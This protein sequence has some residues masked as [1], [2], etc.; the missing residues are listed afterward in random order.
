MLIV[1]ITFLAFS[2][3][4]FRKCYNK[5]IKGYA[6]L[7]LHKLSYKFA[8]IIYIFLEPLSLGIYYL[9]R[10]IYCKYG[11]R[12]KDFFKN[13]LLWLNYKLCG[14]FG[15]ILFDNLLYSASFRNHM[16][17]SWIITFIS[18]YFFSTVP[19]VAF[20][21][22]IAIFTHSIIFLTITWLIFSNKDNNKIIVSKCKICK[23]FLITP[24]II[25]TGCLGAVTTIASFILPNISIT[26][27]S[28]MNILHLCNIDIYFEKYMQFSGIILLI[29]ILYVV[30][31]PVMLSFFIACKLLNILGPI[32][33]CENELDNQDE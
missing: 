11:N 3:F 26:L 20:F 24:I 5:S 17:N 6:F 29:P 10:K 2:I 25:F 14:L 30:L 31:Y 12:N 16:W 7:L 9:T 18:M 8:K 21:A 22:C 23:R 15:N 28:I 19:N 4:Y 1:T 27:S 32:F 13:I 33:Y